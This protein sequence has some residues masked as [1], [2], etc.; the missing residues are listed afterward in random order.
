MPERDSVLG[1]M[2]REIAANLDKAERARLTA[3][4]I[5][6]NLAKDHRANRDV[7]GQIT[8]NGQKWSFDRTGATEAGGFTVYLAPDA[9]VGL[10]RPIGYAL[11]IE[12][13]LWRSNRFFGSSGELPFRTKLYPT[14]LSHRVTLPISLAYDE[15]A[16]AIGEV[17]RS[18]SGGT[19]I[20]ISL[21]LQGDALPSLTF[22]PDCH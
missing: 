4:Q 17:N 11:A 3:V 7:S 12:Q 21:S 20:E 18:L 2:V 1:P 10:G 14:G 9:Y 16:V 6:G 19:P 22:V 5:K 8:V 13:H 15:V